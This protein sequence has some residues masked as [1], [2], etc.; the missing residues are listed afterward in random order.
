MFQF[1]NIFRKEKKVDVTEKQEL[2]HFTSDKSKEKVAARKGEIGEYKI[3][4]QLSQFPKNYLYIND[5]LVRN[6]KSL[7]GYSQIDHVIIT[8]YGIF[9]IET[10]NYQGTVYGGKDRKT[11][12]VNGKFKMMNPLNQNYGH[13]KAL[14][15]YID[16]KY[17]QVFVSIIS[18][19]K[20]CTFKIDSELRKIS[21]DE[22]VVYDVELT[23]FINRKIAV[24]KLQHEEPLLKHEDIAT[25]YN[26]F[27]SANI[28]D[29]IIREE[30]KLSI[31]KQVKVNEVNNTCVICNKQV[32]E[33]VKSYCLSNKKF[34]GKVYCYNHQNMV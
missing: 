10:K 7:S 28:T 31:Q 11:W 32:S 23:E 3:D 21:S 9:V 25:I 12:S 17:E 22:L 2:S 15:H 1:M 16:K 14:L 8:P 13:I 6:S 34:K 5:L 18:F 30:H 27:L 33:K 19:T 20:R 29:T 4:I 24:R 26:V